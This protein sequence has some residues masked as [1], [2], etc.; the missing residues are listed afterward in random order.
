MD[1]SAQVNINECENCNIFIAPCKGSIMLRKSKNICMISAS[2]Q[3]RCTEL[4]DSKL[5]IFCV[6]QPGLESV[7]NISLGCFC[8][9]YTELFD[10]FVKAELNIWQNCWSEYHLFTPEDQNFIKYFQV[11]N[12][13]VF[14][15]NY[16]KAL[17]DQEISI[18]QYFP[19]P[20]TLGLS[21]K[22]TSD[23][24]H[25]LVFMREINIDQ[26]VLY[27]FLNEENLKL[28]SSYL[29]KTG[30]VQRHDNCIHD[31]ENLLRSNPSSIQKS[32]YFNANFSLTPTLSKTNTFTQ[33]HKNTSNG[34]VSQNKNNF[35]VLW[36][37]SD[38]N[39]PELEQVI[40][41]E[42]DGCLSI[43]NNDIAKLEEFIKKIYINFQ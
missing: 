21:L 18:D 36:I 30:I 7:K 26:K 28:S 10:L 11:R 3:L 41:G 34:F 5:S 4:Q 37:V 6:S 25:M 31:L 2:S 42:F 13:I 17:K 16:N 20:L 35:L 8:F 43:N 23:Y 14:I 33:S 15:E 38:E 39:F 12:D 27:D 22:Y 40:E 29:I 1:Y 32:D 19:V 24:K 9:G